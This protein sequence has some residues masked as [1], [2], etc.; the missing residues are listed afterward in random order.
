MV[1]VSNETSARVCIKTNGTNLVM[2]SM[3][4]AMSVSVRGEAG[5]VRKINVLESARSLARAQW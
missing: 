1:N 4:N 2:L 5:P 3:L